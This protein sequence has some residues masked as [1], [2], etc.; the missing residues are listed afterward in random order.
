MLTG[1]GNEQVA[2]DAM[3][4]GVADYVPKR[5][6]DVETLRRVVTNALANFELEQ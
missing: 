5:D 2:V 4:A 3:K 1:Q 6:L